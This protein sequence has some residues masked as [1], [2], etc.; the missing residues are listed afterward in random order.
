MKNNYKIALRPNEDGYLDDIVV[1]DVQLFRMEDMGDY[2][3][4]ACYFN[5]MDSLV[6][7]VDKSDEGLAFPISSPEKAKYEPGSLR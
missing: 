1:K 6:I 3:W 4:I 5:D 7:H 2:W